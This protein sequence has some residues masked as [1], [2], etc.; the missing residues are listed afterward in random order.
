MGYAPR[1]SRLHG[2]LG[3]FLDARQQNQCRRTCAS[4]RAV[5]RLVARGGIVAPKGPVGALD[6]TTTKQVM[7]LFQQ[8]HAQGMTIV[9]VTHDPTIARYA[10]RTVTFSDG[11]V[12]S[13]ERRA[14]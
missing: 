8:L 7:E 11:A 12:I 13:D 4:E 2:D 10:A 14:Q 9:I 5:A 1:R 3:E 6:S